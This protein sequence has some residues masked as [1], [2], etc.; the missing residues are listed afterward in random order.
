LITFSTFLTFHAHKYSCRCWYFMDKCHSLQ[1]LPVFDAFRCLL[2]ITFSLM[3]ILFY[4]VYQSFFGLSWLLIPSSNVISAYSGKLE[5]CIR[6]TLHVQTAL[7]YVYVSY[8]PMSRCA[9]LFSCLIFSSSIYCLQQLVFS[10]ITP[11]LR[12]VCVRLLF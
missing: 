2:D 1:T 8:V 3:Q 11:L 9:I 5:L 6:F 7:I 12:V 4:I 10:D